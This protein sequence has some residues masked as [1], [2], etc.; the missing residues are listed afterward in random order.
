VR[1]SPRCAADSSRAPASRPWKHASCTGTDDETHNERRLTAPRRELELR[2]RI[3]SPRDQRRPRSRPLTIL[4]LFLTRTGVE[5]W[6]ELI[7]ELKEEEIVNKVGGR[8]KLSRDPA[9][10][11]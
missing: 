2:G 11:A 3:M 5:R 9:Q 4:P 7:D 1:T 10:R 6:K 8:F